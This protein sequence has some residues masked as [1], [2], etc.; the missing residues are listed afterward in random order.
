MTS[1]V[2]LHPNTGESQKTSLKCALA[3]ALALGIGCAAAN[4]ATVTGDPSIDGWTNFGNSLQPGV[5]VRGDA[6][7]SF[8]VYTTALTV[9]SGSD[10]EIDDGEFSWQAGDLVLGAGAKFTTITSDEAGWGTPITGINGLLDP[11][12]Q[13]LQVKFGTSAATWSPSTVA[14]GGGNGSG[15]GGDGGGTVLVRT[16][17]Y[18]KASTHP[19]QV[20]DYTLDGDAGTLLPVEKPDHLE[21]YLGTISDR[22]ARMIWTYDEDGKHAAA[23]EFLLNVSLMQRLVPDFDGLLPGV[24]DLVIVTVQDNDNKYTDALAVVP[25]PA[26]LSLLGVGM[27]GLLRRRRQ[28]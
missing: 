12:G 13:K 14:P 17:A 22:V 9:T 7:F 10:L 15:S 4:A 6:N 1:W 21:W 20:S 5:Y 24:G 28:A 11:N 2:R 3:G 27:L 23:F 19:E 18:L 16:S 25:E 8:D 26:T